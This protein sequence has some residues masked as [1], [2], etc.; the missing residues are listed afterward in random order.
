[1]SVEVALE[2]EYADLLSHPL[3][4]SVEIVRYSVNR[5][6][7]YLRARCRLIN[8]DYLEIALHLTSSDQGVLIDD[9]RYQWMDPTRTLLKRRWDNAPHFSNLPRY[10]HHCHVG[11]EDV[12]EP[13][14]PMK[15]AQLLDLI[16]ELI[17]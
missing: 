7:G 1:M 2:S 10:P 8:G 14:V 6:D 17:A 15:L 16:S 12:V 9:Y 3:V 4:H 11:D 5:L 13:G